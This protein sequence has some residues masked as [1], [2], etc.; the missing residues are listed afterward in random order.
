MRWQDLPTDEVVARYA[1]GESARD[2][3]RVYGAAHRTVLKH[4]HAVGA[5]VRDRNETQRVHFPVAEAAERYAAGEPALTLARAYGVSSTTVAYW[6]RAV[7]IVS[8]GR[9]GRPRK[10]GGSFF[11][12]PQGYLSTTDRDGRA[13]VV[14]RA[15]WE[16][17][18]GPIPPKHDVHHP[19]GNRLDNRIE[20]LECLPHAEHTRWHQMKVKAWILSGF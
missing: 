2:I 18:Y 8:R 12:S 19:N 10:R 3:G 7:G 16:A 13:C 17:H 9:V 15:C 5:E 4:L 20:N 14:H 1:A 6:L 11:I